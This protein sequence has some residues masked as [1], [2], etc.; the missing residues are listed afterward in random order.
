MNYKL[1]I[2]N[3]AVFLSI[4]FATTDIHHNA[5]DKG[6]RFNICAAGS[7]DGWVLNSMKVWLSEKTVRE[8]R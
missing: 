1:L 8:D 2:N 3:I 4:F 5:S 7:M 6:R